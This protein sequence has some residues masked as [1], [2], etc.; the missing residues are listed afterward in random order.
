MWS[1]TDATALLHLKSGT[2]S[3]RAR[4]LAE[5]VHHET[6][7]LLAVHEVC[8]WLGGLWLVAALLHGRR[9][10]VPLDCCGSRVSLE[11]AARPML[12]RDQVL[13]N[14]FDLEIVLIAESV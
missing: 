2:R 11:P 8:A 1:A 4:D 10:S 14:D 3:D 5:L 9:E 6:L 12:L 13:R 7:V